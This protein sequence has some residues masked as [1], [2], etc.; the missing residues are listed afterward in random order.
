M[1]YTYDHIDHSGQDKTVTDS[2]EIYHNNL[3]VEKENRK[4]EENNNIQNNENMKKVEVASLN[5]GRAKAEAVHRKVFPS[6]FLK[7]MSYV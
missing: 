7:K 2:V 5:L 3:F 1:K 4:T 6:N